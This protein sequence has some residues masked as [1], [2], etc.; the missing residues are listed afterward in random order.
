MGIGKVI[1][2]QAYKPES[3]TSSPTS[4]KDPPVKPSVKLTITPKTTKDKGKGKERKDF[5]LV[6]KGGCTERLAL[7]S[8]S[9]RWK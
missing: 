9:E 6:S 5:V 2:G 1:L 3:F 8:N 7:K 4:K